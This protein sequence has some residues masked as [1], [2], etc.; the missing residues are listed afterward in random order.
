MNGLRPTQ[1]L[2]NDT[3][4]LYFVCTCR[5]NQLN[6]W[7]CLSELAMMWTTQELLPFATYLRP[8]PMSLSTS[9]AFLWLVTPEV[10]ISSIRFAY[11]SSFFCKLLMLCVDFWFFFSN[12]VLIRASCCLSSLAPAAR[13]RYSLTFSEKSN[14][15]CHKTDR[16]YAVTCIYTVTQIYQ[17]IASGLFNIILLGTKYWQTWNI[18]QILKHSFITKFH[19]PVFS[20]SCLQTYIHVVHLWNSG[21]EIQYK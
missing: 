11:P 9:L 17:V 3:V 4:M 8:W 7:P 6:F 10:W 14:S 18:L 16:Q 21:W 2:V 13:R 19:N 12:T 15:W 20:H 1:E 5:E